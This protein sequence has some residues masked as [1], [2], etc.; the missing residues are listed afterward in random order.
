M[1]SPDFDT[2]AA[3]LAQETPDPAEMERALQTVNVD[4]WDSNTHGTLLHLA[5]RYDTLH[6]R[7]GRWARVLVEK[8]GFGVNKQGN[9]GSIPALWAI[10]AYV[11]N[12]KADLETLRYLLSVSSFDTNAFLTLRS[13]LRRH[14]IEQFAHMPRLQSVLDLLKRHRKRRISPLLLVR[15]RHRRYLFTR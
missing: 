6:K 10:S 7:K 13:S 4:Y 3:L 5:A 12:E 8:Y 9:E 2:A 1:F 14:L 11:Y 15:F